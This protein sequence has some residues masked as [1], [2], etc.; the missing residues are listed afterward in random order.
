VRFG[1]GGIRPGRRACAA[2]SL[3]LFG[4]GLCSATAFYS[5]VLDSPEDTVQIALNLTSP[6]DVTLQT[7]GFGGGTDA[8]GIIVPSGGFDPFVGLFSGTGATATFIDGTSD[9]L[10]NYPSEP[11]ACGPAGLVTVGTVPGQCG[12]VRLLFSDLA[13]GTYT[14]V[15]S[16]AEY[17][18]VAVQETNGV[19]GDGFF[20]LTGGSFPLQTCATSTDCNNDTANWALDITAPTSA[21]E[22]ATFG[23]AGLGL[24]IAA[25]VSWRRR[26]MYSRSGG[27]S[28]GSLA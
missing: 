13:A 19:L 3:L 2:L 26:R 23:L 6:G 12:D 8:N 1:I 18:P 17:F 10:S 21:P 11:N 20:D 15:L 24:A 28:R 5:G 25:S 4:A 9:I 22:P 14:V 7:Y 27:R 16:D